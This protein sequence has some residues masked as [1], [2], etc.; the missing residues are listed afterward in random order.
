MRQKSKI[1]NDDF[2]KQRNS[3]TQYSAKK[4]LNIIFKIYT[5]ESVIDFGCGVGTWL[6][7]AKKIGA[8][9]VKGLD[10][11]YVNRKYLV[12]AQ[13]EFVATN[14]SQK[15]NLNEKYDLAISLEVAEH[16]PKQR[17]KSFVDDLCNASDVVLFSAAIKDQGGGGHINEQRMSYWIDLFDKRGYRVND[18]IRPLI[19]NDRRIPVWYRQN[20]VVFVNSNANISDVDVSDYPDIYDFVHPELYEDKIKEYEKLRNKPFV[21]G[22]LKLEKILNKIWK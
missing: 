14:L 16:L 17:A 11:D 3:Q 22:Y 18:I 6:R 5:V 12:I 1:Y 7:E 13:N 4:I 9:Q 20:I 2:Y 21:R 8:K 15:V 10:G 19:W